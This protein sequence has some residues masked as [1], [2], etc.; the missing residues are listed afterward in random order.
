MAD[1][2]VVAGLA[3]CVNIV[4]GVTSVYMWGGELQRDQE[5]TLL[6]KVAEAGV[7]ALC[8]GIRQLHSYST[9]EIVVLP[10]LVDESDPAYLAWVRSAGG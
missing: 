5:H 2:L 10:V 9:P 1:K 6:I 4:P 7:Q 8:D 3:A